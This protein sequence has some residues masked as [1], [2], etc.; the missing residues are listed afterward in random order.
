MKFSK[1]IQKNKKVLISLISLVAFALFFGVVLADGPTQYKANGYAYG[2]IDDNGD[3]QADTGI[4]YLSFGCE[5][6][7]GNACSNTAT[8]DF[9]SGYGVRI[10]TDAGSPDNGKIFGHAWSSNYGWVSFYH[11]DVSSCGSGG[12]LEIPGDVQQFISTP[13]SSTVLNGWARVLNHDNSGWDGCIRFGEDAVNGFVEPATLTAVSQNNLVMSGWAYGSPLVG[14][15]SFDCEYCNVTFEPVEDVECDEADESEECNPED[16]DDPSGSGNEPG[17][18]LYVGQGNTALNS[19]YP[20]TGITL[21]Y[22]GEGSEMEIKLAPSAQFVDVYNCSASYTS[23]LNGQASGWSGGFSQSYMNPLVANGHPMDGIEFYVD[24][25]DYVGDEI[26]TFNLDC[27]TTDADDPVSASATVTMKYPDA[28]V[29]ITANPEDVDIG[30]S[31]VISW[32]SQY[33][34][35]DSCEIVGDYDLVPEIN[36]QGLTQ[37]DQGYAGSIGF[38]NLGNV[39]PQ[40]SDDV[41][42]L[43]W[44][45]GFELKCNDLQG[46]PVSDVAYID[47]GDVGC[48]GDLEYYCEGNLAPIFEEF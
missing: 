29:S 38:A 35:P 6:D 36:G 18:E 39:N 4:G 28:S 2:A 19:L 41:Y 1:S 34:Q 33:V 8:Q 3:N 42:S 12:G 48:V 27:L 45:T 21:P 46:N 40:G 11:G 15:I 30:G 17:L 22:L 23:T 24:L 10:N 13:G 16:P 5:G 32:T 37:M 9:P 47:V 44:P 25:S 20:T 31:S 43:Q 7:V 26:Y 14:W